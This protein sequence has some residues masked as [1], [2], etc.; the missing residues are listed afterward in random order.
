[1][2]FVPGLI[3]SLFDPNRSPTRPIGQFV[4]QAHRLFEVTCGAVVRW[5]V[6]GIPDEYPGLV[7][8]VRTNKK[9]EENTG[10]TFHGLPLL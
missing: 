4:P 2:S 1:M 6:R 3:D 9:A 10:F 5:I 8:N 7:E